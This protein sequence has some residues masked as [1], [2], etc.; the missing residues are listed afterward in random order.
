MRKLK[1]LDNNRDKNGMEEEQGHEEIEQNSR[2][3][4]VGKMEGIGILKK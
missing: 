3:Y 1:N 2:E 4:D